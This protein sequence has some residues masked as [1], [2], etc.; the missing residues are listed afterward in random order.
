MPLDEERRRDA[1]VVCLYGN[2]RVGASAEELKETLQRLAQ[3]SGGPIVLD[4]TDLSM[5]DSTALDIVAGCGRTLHADGRELYLAGPNELVALLLKIT[6]ID[7][8]FPVVPTVEAALQS[9]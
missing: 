9:H 7:G 5:L 3:E 6:K 2:L 8:L 1:V 4:L